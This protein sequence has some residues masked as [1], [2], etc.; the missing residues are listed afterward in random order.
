MPQTYDRPLEVD[1]LAVLA[2]FML[3]LAGALFAADHAG[4]AID[5]DAAFGLPLILI[6][7][8]MI[9]L[10]KTPFGAVR[11]SWA[12]LAA[13]LVLASLGMFA[14]FI[15]GVLT[16][17]ARLAVGIVLLVGGFG[18]LIQLVFASGQARSWLRTG[19]VLTEITIACAL[20]YTLSIVAGALVLLRDAVPLGWQA[21]AYLVYGVVLAFTAL[22]LRRVARAYPENPPTPDGAERRPWLRD[23][24]L[25][26][27]LANFLLT[28]VSLTL[29]GALL[30]PV[31]LG[32][33]P[34]APNGQFGVMLVL[35]AIQ[36]MAL[37]A[38]PI[39]EVTRPA[40]MAAIGLAFAA[41][42]IAASL[43]PDLPSEWLNAALGL[44]NLGGGVKLV[45]NA[46]GP[47]SGPP[48][49]PGAA[50]AARPGP[51]AL[52]RIVR[53]LGVLS[54]LFGLTVFAPG[55]LPLFAL[56][57][58]LVLMGLLMFALVVLLRSKQA[59]A[60]PALA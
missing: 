56:A 55:A 15:P 38:T 45:L 33:L 4:V 58:L 28:G 21:A 27:P 20:A 32:K 43:L 11:R 52:R 37:G 16:S 22:T 41:I 3:I 6:A 12:L 40:L 60:A 42:G 2:I 54:I 18:L 50:P 59:A 5:G 14:C 17:L 44:L 1:F 10:G 25:S 34:Y 39:G 35:M 30:F 57:G 23:P 8:E 48:R 47:P 9:S 31:G 13:G 7:F 36:A 53:A 19:G 49:Q 26:L 51:K 29:F 24:G 46:G